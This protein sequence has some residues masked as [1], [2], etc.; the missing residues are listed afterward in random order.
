[1]GTQESQVSGGMNENG[2]YRLIYLIAW[3]NYL[4][5]I[6]GYD[7]VG[8]GVSLGVWLQ[9][10]PAIFES[11]FFFLLL[12]VWSMNYQLFLPTSYCSIIMNSVPL[13]PQAQLQ[14]SFY[15]LS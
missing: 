12:V 9:E 1:M 7:L 4:K 14:F 3:W 11:A 10:T 15:K 2:L 8:G 6:R 13:E 5:R